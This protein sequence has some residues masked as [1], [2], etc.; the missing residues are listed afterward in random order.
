MN[1]MPRLATFSPFVCAGVI[2]AASDVAW[3][4]DEIEWV[5]TSRGRYEVAIGAHIWPGIAK[6]QP[7]GGGTFDEVGLN[8]NF[9]AHWSVKRFA[10]SELLVGFDLGLSSNESDIRSLTDDVIARNAYLVPSIKWMFGRRHRYSIDAGIGCYLLDIAEVAGEY[11]VITETQVWE[12]S[13]LGAY[14]GGTVNFGGG[15]PTNSHGVMLS[16]KTHFVDFGTVHDEDIV[17]PTTLG[18]DAGDLSGPVYMLQIGY[19]W[20]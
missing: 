12:E 16:F 10:S 14:V 13:S 1:R 18:Q 7:P 17:F 3:A 2:L 15:S 9:A 6:L 19:R 4:D 20:R 8:L 5:T 11:P